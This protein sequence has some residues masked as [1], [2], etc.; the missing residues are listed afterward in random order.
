MRRI[1][2]WL[3]V[4]TASLAIIGAILYAFGFRIVMYGGGMPHFQFVRSADAQA[5]AIDAHRAAQRVAPPPPPAGAAT[6]A[7][8]AA[9][10]EL[11]KPPGPRKVSD[12]ADPAVAPWPQF[13]GPYR[14][15]R[16]RAAIRTDW[17]AAGLTPMWKQPIGG[18]YASFAVAGGLAFTIE[19]RRDEEVVAAYDVMTGREIW[20]QKWTARFSETMGGD[21]PRAT[22]TWHDG[23]L[24]ALGATGEFAA[25]DAATGRPLWRTNI[26][27]DARAGNLQWGMAASPLI[28][29][30]TV[31]VLPGGSNG[32]SVVAYDRRTGKRAW[33]SLSD[34]QAYVAPMLATVAGVRQLIVVSA[35]RMIGLS[36]D[37]GE[38]L[39]EYSWTTSYDINA[40]QPLLVSPTRLFISSG[41]GQGAAVI[42]VSAAAG[43]LSAREVWKNVRMKNRF[44]S[45]VLHDGFIY[46]FDEN[47]LACM[48]AAT[49]ALKWKGGRYGY[50]ELILAS[51]QLIVLSEDGELALVRAAPTA[52][53]ELARGPALEGK[54]WNHPAMD[55]GILLIR[56]A[57]EMAAF[58][59]RL[60]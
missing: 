49:G 1:L 59:L 57:Q 8:P 20:T 35:S 7:N 42:E 10:P 3:A 54:T 39:W 22:P 25:L 28:V 46:G 31:V 51:G 41:Y 23:R 36:P 56:N 38:L 60:K 2:K 50:G 27:R 14:D 44:A 24:Y 6:L 32:K 53:E 37:K 16:I 29:G 58:D 40:A 30:D 26:L 9:V 17:P 18:G 11:P 13:R 12:V 15:G 4:L 55:R 21:G 19:Q 48:D 52:H 33:S 5:D 45:S 34:R 47:I 43:A